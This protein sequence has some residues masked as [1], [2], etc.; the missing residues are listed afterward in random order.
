MIWLLSRSLPAIVVFRAWLFLLS[1]T[2]RCGGPPWIVLTPC[3]NQPAREH[4]FLFSWMSICGWT[5]WVTW[6]PALILEL[7]T[8]AAF[9][10]VCTS[11]TGGLLFPSILANTCFLSVCIDWKR[12]HY[13]DVKFISVITNET[14]VDY[15][16]CSLDCIANLRILLGE[17][18]F[19]WFFNFKTY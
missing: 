4:I 12:C 18:A 15:M 16:I 17:T 9:H 6:S 10:T 8:I 11:K 19:K 1:L 7:L 2:I 14:M 3:S 13:S 5:C